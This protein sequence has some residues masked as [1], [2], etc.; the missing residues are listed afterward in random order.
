MME[1]WR[2]VAATVIAAAASGGAA[3]QGSAMRVTA[4]MPDKLATGQELELIVEIEL[5]RGWSASEDGPGRPLLQLDV[6][7]TVRLSGRVLETY[8][9]LS[10]NE[11]LEE[12]YERQA[13]FGEN[14]VRLTVLESSDEDDRLG[15]N[16]VAYLR[17]PDGKAT[18][19]RRRVD[20]PVRTGASASS[21]SRADRSGWGR[22]GTLQIGDRAA[23]LMLPRA[24]GTEFDLS[25][26][27]GQRPIVITT[28]RAHW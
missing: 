1:R 8:Q 2:R 10:R 14:P 11:F 12:P 17:S 18:F 5:G 4:R 24:D 7:E 26:V 20:L 9:Q 25:L 28:Y 23:A 16:V 19:V 15:I 6:P 21:D 22:N 13:T 3:G 27:L